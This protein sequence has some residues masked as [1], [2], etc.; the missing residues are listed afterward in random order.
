MQVVMEALIAPV[1]A[2]SERL[3]IELSYR[4][5]GEIAAQPRVSAASAVSSAKGA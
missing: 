5:R 3:L 4:I 2:G 1:V